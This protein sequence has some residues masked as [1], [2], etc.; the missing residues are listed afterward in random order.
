MARVF[1]FLIVLAFCIALVAMLYSIWTTIR[2]ASDRHLRPIFGLT[3]ENDM[4]PSGIQKAAYIALIVMLFGVASG[5][6]GGM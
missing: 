4:A 1:L 3:E 5:W 6:L 2:Q